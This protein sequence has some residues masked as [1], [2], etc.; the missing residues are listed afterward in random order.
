LDLLGDADVRYYSCV[1]INGL[2]AREW[3]RDEGGVRRTKEENSKR[4]VDYQ[5]T[6]FSS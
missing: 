6:C 1:E 3:K 2:T 4:E 5:L